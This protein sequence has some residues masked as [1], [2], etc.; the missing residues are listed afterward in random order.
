MATPKTN[1]K[2]LMKISIEKLEAMNYRDVAGDIDDIRDSL[3]EKGQLE[4]ITVTPKIEEGKGTD[5]F[6]IVNGERRF[7]AA[8]NIV[9]SGRETK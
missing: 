6:I 7:R 5:R 3:L 8:K 1:E 4:P 9:E 2:K